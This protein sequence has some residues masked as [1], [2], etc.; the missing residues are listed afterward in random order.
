MKKLFIL[1]GLLIGMINYSNAT[2]YY[3]S[4]TGSNS[5]NGTSQSTPWLSISKLATVANAGTIHAGDNIYFQRGGTYTGTTALI[6]NIWGGSAQSGTALQPIT[7]GA[8]G[9]GARPVIYYT[10]GG[11][12][13]TDAR[14]VFWLVGVNYWIFQDLDFTDLA[15]PAN[16]KYEWSNSCTAVYLGSMGD[17][18]CNHCIVRRCNNA[19]YGAFVV[20]VGDFNQIVDCTGSDYKNVVSSDGSP[21]DGTMG[22][23]EYEDYGANSFTITGS[24]NKITRDTI[25]GAWC[26]SYDFGWNGGFCEMY[27]QC[28]RDTISYCIITDCGGISEFGSSSH[29]GSS[30]N[31]VF[32][33][34]RIINCGGATYANMSGSFAILV[35]A[36]KWYNNVIVETMSS[37]FTGT[38]P[39]LGLT[40]QVAINNLNTDDAVFTHNGS[41]T[42]PVNIV[43]NNIFY[44]S[45]PMKVYRNSETQLTKDHNIYRLTGS[46]TLGLTKDATDST[47]S[48]AIFTNTT[49]S[50][51]ADWDFTPL[52][53]SPA[54]DRGTAISGFT[55]D[56]NGN[57]IGG[58]TNIG[59]IESASTSSTLAP[60]ATS[61]T[62]ACN[63]GTTTVTVAATGGTSPYT[64]TGT[65]T[66]SA[67]TYSYNVTDATSTVRSV[68]ITVTQPPTLALTLSAGT[69][70]SVGGTT[71]ITVTAS[72]GTSTK[73][74]SM[75][76]G[77]Y[78][79]SNLF[80]AS[81]G[82]RTITV[83]DANNCTKSATISIA[84]YVAP[85]VGGGKRWFCNSLYTGTTQTGDSLTPWKTLA[86]VS[87]AQSSFQAGDFILFARGGTY[88]GSMTIS[89]SG[90]STAQITYGAY[91]T[92][93]KPLF[94]G[95]GSTIQ[96]LFYMN[97]RNYITFQDLEIKDP[98]IDV[99]VSTNPTRLIKSKIERAFEMDGTSSFTI[100][101]RCRI[102]AVGVGAFWVGPNN[103]MDSCD[104]GDLTMVVDTPDDNDG[105]GIFGE[106]PGDQPGR[107]DD[108]GANPLVISSANNV[109]TNNYFFRCWAHSYD[110][111]VDGGAVEIYG[112]GCNNNYIAYNTIEDNLGITEFTKTS[113][114]NKFHYNKIV[115]C[116]SIF[117]FQNTGITNVEFFNNVVVETAAP[118]EG[119]SSRLFAGTMPIGTMNWSNNIF[120]LTAAV[121]VANSSANT[122]QI[123]ENNIYKVSGSG[124]IGFTAGA[125]ELSTSAAIWANTTASNPVNWDFTPAPNS[126]AIDFGKNLGLTKDIKGTT[127]PNVPNAGIIEAGAAQVV[128]TAVATVTTPIAC[129]GGT[130][131][132][133]VSGSGGTAPYSG[134][135]TFNKANGTWSFTVTDANSVSG[136]TSVT[137]VEPPAITASGSAPAPTTV[138]GTAVL[139]VVA[140]GGTAPLTYSMDGGSFQSGN[141][142]NAL[143]GNRSITVKDANNCTKVI[144]VTVPAAVV[145]G[146]LA[147]NVISVTGNSCKGKS[148]GS[149]TVSGSGGRTPYQFRITYGFFNFYQTSATFSNLRP[150]TY[151]V[152]VKDAL[153]VTKYTN[154]TIPSSTVPCP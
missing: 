37:R 110:Y 102:T 52:S 81:A 3:I 9:T 55:I 138:G 48:A 91:G 85:P 32:A 10:P 31:N 112:D 99:N 100:I 66:V 117:Y 18:T 6:Q 86:Q 127:V 144:T 33:Y 7:I 150:G 58:S 118:R 123:H 95:T 43:K 135:G 89:K 70:T 79:S 56:V 120:N 154:V 8:Y 54:I 139:T 129:Q 142:F 17:A 34:N 106:I 36:N 38:Q 25:S 44:L 11:S 152:T 14:Q 72:G 61:G 90:T 74:Y 50:N 42:Q 64:G 114:G 97:N 4:P 83:K 47:T 46:A 75:D 141:T 20:I 59:P 146:T 136:T 13:K 151:R 45:T 24:D 132:I 134:T 88:P 60:T 131:V 39:G 73:T 12:T 19:H 35:Y 80:T 115:N 23:L 29:A 62:I 143:S 133:T 67:G 116:G 130:G 69:I 84:A 93:N 71:T 94:T 124:S 109:V 92:G 126:P 49:S 63:G 148:N 107:D 22:R 104:V 137:I 41:P 21:Y 98:T 27:E 82:V 65:F 78:Q 128:V 149:C 122:S 5:N 76:G 68:S 121:S 2:D 30:N 15:F 77:A 57:S 103:T 147:I 96:V 125:T 51:P 108:Y 16:N 28:Q 119:S 105:D 40:H 101:K 53:T 140:A 153:G 26:E 113:T 87:A 145:S 111:T 1:V